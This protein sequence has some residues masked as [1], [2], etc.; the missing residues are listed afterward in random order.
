GGALVDPG[1]AL[2][3]ARR[4]GGDRRGVLHCGFALDSRRQR[5]MARAIEHGG[6]RVGRGAHERLVERRFAVHAEQLEVW[7]IEER[8]DVVEE[9]RLLHAVASERVK[10]A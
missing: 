1:P 4:A 3:W 7:R 2:G 8:P 5:A 10:D 6:E 9:G